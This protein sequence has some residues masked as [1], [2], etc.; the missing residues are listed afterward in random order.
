MPFGHDVERNP[1]GAPILGGEVGG[2]Y[3]DLLCKVRTD[4]VDQAPIGACIEVAD[5]VHGHIVGVG[6]VA[7]H[8]LIGGLSEVV[9]LKWSGLVT[10]APGTSVSSSM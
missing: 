5:S 8:R 7:V 6:A 4:V 9:M 2:L 3:F 10:T 1:R